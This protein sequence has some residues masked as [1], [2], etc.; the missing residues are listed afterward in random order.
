MHNLSDAMIEIVLHQEVDLKGY[1]LIEGFPGAGL[2]GPMAASYMIEK[3]GMKGLGHI[4]SDLF[5][6]I[7][8]VHDGEPMHTARI[9][10]DT[11]NKL[12]VVLSEFTIPQGVV[13]QLANE[14]LSFMRKS[15]IKE[16]VSIGGMPSQHPSDTAYVISSEP[17]QAKK[18]A[19]QGLKPVKE[20]VIA[21]VSALLITG[22]K[23]FGI[24]ALDVLVEVNPVIMDPKYAEVAISGLSKLLDIEIDTKELES[25]AREVE[26]RVREMVK[27]AKSSHEHYNKATEEVGPPSVA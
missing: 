10:L 2:V 16:V 23:G 9:Y 1:V 24:P 5:P 3:L 11:K 15:G 4:E 27:Q 17:D 22:A 14:L 6:P 8:A 26:A 21:G 18:A 7:A 25:E 13:Y 20:G 19:K 12:V